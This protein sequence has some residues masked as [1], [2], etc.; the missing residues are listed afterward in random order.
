MQIKI[1]IA[2]VEKP[3]HNRCSVFLYLT[4]HAFFSGIQKDK[5]QK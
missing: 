3:I 5:N 2:A 4:S 1:C